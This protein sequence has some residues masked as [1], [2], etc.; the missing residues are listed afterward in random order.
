MRLL[1]VS[2]D[3]P[4]EIGGIANHVDNLSENLALIGHQVEVLVMKAISEKNSQLHN[5]VEV[6][7]NV[8]VH[9]VGYTVSVFSLIRYRN[10]RR[11]LRQF[12]K[13]NGSFEVIHVH[14]YRASF[15]FL[16][17]FRKST[18]RLIVTHHSSEFLYNCAKWRQRFFDRFL[19]RSVDHMIS[20]SEELRGL[21]SKV[22]SKPSVYI[23]NGVDL[24]KFTYVSSR[25][26]VDD[27]VIFVPR[28]MQP[29]NGVHFFVN[30]LTQ[31]TV[32]KNGKNILVLI[33]GDD[34]A[35]NIDSDYSNLVKEKSK[36]LPSFVSIE[37][38][39]N[40]NSSEMNSYYGK[41]HLTVIPS[42]VEATSLSALEA[43]ACGS[44]L[45]ASETG[46]LTQLIS[47]GKN[48]FL[49]KVG[50]EEDLARN[51]SEIISNFDGLVDMRLKA[52]MDVEREYM[53]GKIA[54][55][56]EAVYFSE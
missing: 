18:S 25:E 22:I 27:F 50:D 19:L 35:V 43:M 2:S 4:P 23:S 46:G 40:L 31:L 30:S 28:R 12:F 6:R 11:K 29:K 48:G 5:S 26:L 3:F 41:S 15:K 38:L 42:L 1:L 7:K 37:F 51:V 20:P 10:Q 13:S 33:T 16:S 34:P 52:R 32:P 54:R 39:G 36:T 9:Y 21:S 14:D 8:K 17:I 47:H 56:T 45:L 44:I 53:W 55:L 49:A 24:N